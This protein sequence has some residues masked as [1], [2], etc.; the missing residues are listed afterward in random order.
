MKML[1]KYYKNL[2][3][4][5]FFLNITYKNYIKLYKNN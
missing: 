2:K 1:Q 3:F 5:G 4:A